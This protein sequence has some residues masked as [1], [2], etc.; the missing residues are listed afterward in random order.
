MNSLEQSLLPITMLLLSMYL[1]RRLPLILDLLD[2][3]W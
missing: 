2:L 3:L 1:G